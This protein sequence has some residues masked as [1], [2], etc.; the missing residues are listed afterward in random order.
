MVASEDL[1]RH[2]DKRID[3]N[4][5]G[6]EEGEI[7]RLIVCIDTNKPKEVVQVG[8]ESTRHLL[9]L[10]HIKERTEVVTFTPISCSVD[11]LTSKKI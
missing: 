4:V 7:L 8:K 9:H 2:T 3:T 1:G 10:K 6:G 11:V 5:K